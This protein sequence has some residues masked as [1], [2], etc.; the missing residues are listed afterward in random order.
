MLQRT[1]DGENEALLSRRPS[2]QESDDAEVAQ[3]GEI[4]ATLTPLIVVFA[5]NGLATIADYVGSTTIIE[6]MHA[7]SCAEHHGE[8]LSSIQSGHNCHLTQV[9]ERFS[10]V[11]AYSISLNSFASC[12][13]ALV[14]CPLVIKQLGRERSLL[15][16]AML[17]AL[18]SWFVTYF[19]GRIRLQAQSDGPR[20][21]WHPSPTLSIHMLLFDA[22]LSGLMGCGTLLSIVSNTIILDWVPSQLRATWLARL[23]ASVSAGM[24]LSTLILQSLDL[25][26]GSDLVI[27]LL[28]LRIGATVSVATI[29]LSLTIPRLPLNPSAAPAALSSLDD[30]L[31]PP[32][33]GASF[34]IELRGA[35]TPFR[36]LSSSSNLTKMLVASMMTSEIHVA[37]N[38]Y[39]VYVQSR[40]NFKAKDLSFLSGSVG[41]MSW[42]FLMFLFPT[43]VAWVRKRRL[44]APLSLPDSDSDR[45][46][47]LGSLAMDVISWTLALVAGLWR[48]VAGMALGLVA[49]SLSSG[50]SSTIVALATAFLPAT[51]SN[52]DLVALLY[53][54]DSV[55]RTLG[56]ILNAN[57]YRIGLHLHFPELVFVFTAL[58]SL[59]TMGLISTVRLPCS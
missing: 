9:D 13:S 33:H 26:T 58:L 50:A 16:A 12:I 10:N 14:I 22:V 8:S 42:F 37:T 31:H 5:I 56:P 21:G 51:A 55:M 52:D 49:F 47:A 38:V 54:C 39:A 6:L 48:S 57:I 40:F 11:F 53:T 32:R 20:D 30:P 17:N 59:L 18:D 46:L 24:L 23:T 1:N 41:L 44:A 27:N 4:V 29:L 34:W 25:E 36:L 35:C 19:T 15:A 7:L 43:I 2:H 3:T 45:I 28:P